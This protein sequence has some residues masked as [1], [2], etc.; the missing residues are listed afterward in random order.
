MQS[1][2]KSVLLPGSIG[3]GAGPSFDTSAAQYIRVHVY[4]SD[5]PA[6]STAVVTL[7]QSTDGT[8]WFTSATITNPTGMAVATGDGGEI[9]ALPPCAYTRAFLVS[10]VAGTL[11]AT[12]EV[13]R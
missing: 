9:W 6:A 11:A 1:N 3:V 5:D 10:R 12:I 8:L 7:Q 4:R 13:Q 2:T